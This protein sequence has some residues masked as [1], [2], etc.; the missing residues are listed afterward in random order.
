MGRSDTNPR[1]TQTVALNALVWTL[2]DERRAER[3]VSLTGLT[4]ADLR[5]RLGEPAVL[6]ACLAFLEGHEPDLLACADAIGA[7]PEALVAARA[8]LERAA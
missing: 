3:L 2:G 4:P 8:A 5:A 6:A 7:T 1:D